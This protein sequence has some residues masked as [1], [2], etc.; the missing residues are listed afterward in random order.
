R[1][2]NAVAPRRCGHS[3]AGFQDF[4]RRLGAAFLKK[5]QARIEYQEK[6]D[7]RTFDIIAKRQLQQHRRLEHPR[8]WRPQLFQGPI[9]WMLDRIL[10]GIRSV[11]FSRNSIASLAGSAQPLLRL[12][13]IYLDHLGVEHTQQRQN[14][15]LN[16]PKRLYSDVKLFDV[17][18]IEPIVCGLLAN[19]ECLIAADH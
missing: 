17:P 19:S 1:F 5:S 7:G 4:E 6:R 14:L 12:S 3:Q 8:N 9:D 16:C 10:N 11:Q 13:A 15:T 18:S 2:P